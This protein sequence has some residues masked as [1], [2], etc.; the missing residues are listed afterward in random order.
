M[1]EEI[2]IAAEIIKKIPHVVLFFVPPTEK[3]AAPNLELV[4]HEDDNLKAVCTSRKH[5][6]II[7]TPLN[8]TF[9]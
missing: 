9:I 1:S 2:I 8:P 3:G 6:Y 4:H 7:L 5:A